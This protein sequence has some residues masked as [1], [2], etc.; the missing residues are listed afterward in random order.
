MNKSLTIL[1]YTLVWVLLI[2]LQSLALE[3]AN[4]GTPSFWNMPSSYYAVWIVDA[5]IIA[6][7]YINYFLIAPA[8]IKRLLFR[9][10]IVLS[11]ALGGIGM[12]LPVIFHHAWQ[13]TI[14]GTAEGQ[15]PLYGE[16][17]IA[18]IAAIAVGLSVRGVR[19][20]VRLARRNTNLEI[21]LKNKSIACDRAEARLRS[22]EQPVSFRDLGTGAKVENVPSSTPVSPQTNE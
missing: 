8:M 16:G 18:A 22:L 10:Y 11:L 20:W 12:L 3:S 5:Y 13:W 17:F 21:A 9:P 7:Y 19:E 14:P 1:I 2:V 4:P 15:M 6:L